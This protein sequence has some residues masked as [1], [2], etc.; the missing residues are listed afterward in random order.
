M[1][2]PAGILWE[3]I[4]IDNNSSDNTQEK[5]LSY[6]FN[7]HQAPLRYIKEGNQGVAFA[8]NRG[9][10][11]STGEVIVFMDD[12]EIADTLWLLKILEPFNTSSADCVGGRILVQYPDGYKK[13]AWLLDELEGFIG[14]LDYGGEKPR[15]LDD[16]ETPVFTGNSAFSR[17]VFKEA[18]LFNTQLG[19]RGAQ[20][21]GGEDVEMSGRILKAG[22]SIFYQPE[23]VIYHIIGPDKLKKKYFRKLH[24]FDGEKRGYL[25]DR[26]P[27]KNIFWIPLYIF[28]QFTRSIFRYL[29]NP[30]LRLQMNIWWHMG[31]IKG[32]L[33][34]GFNL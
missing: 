23:A 24:F 14:K 4:V 11:E 25:I 30:T 32:R 28:P 18:G 13:P 19:R 26:Q 15:L 27:G 2:V 20:T 34:S 10:Q 9:I 6:N 5:V 12:D 16:P 33:K 21:F 1:K 22:Y 3:V 17:R 8:R 31:F 29:S 7:N